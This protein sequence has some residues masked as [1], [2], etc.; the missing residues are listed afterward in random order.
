[1]VK[2]L[3]SR[4]KLSF[5]RIVKKQ[6]YY[7]ST[8][9]L[10]TWFLSLCGCNYLIA[11]HVPL[12]CFYDTVFQDSSGSRFTG[13]WWNGLYTCYGKFILADDW[14][15]EGEWQDG[16][17]YG[18]GTVIYPGG[19]KYFGEWQEGVR[20]EKGLEKNSFFSLYVHELVFIFCQEC[21]FSISGDRELLVGFFQGY[22]CSGTGF[23]PAFH[24][25]VGFCVHL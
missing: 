25:F 18:P 21:F 23:D 22:H 12:A 2:S 5:G 7:D 11:E 24:F 9:Y 17:E 13:E 3:F 10:C 20:H 8:R 6:D 4:G 1:M 14:Q 15:C 19:G 16:A